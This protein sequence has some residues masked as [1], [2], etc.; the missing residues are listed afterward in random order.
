MVFEKD[1]P[2]FTARLTIFNEIINGFFR[3]ELVFKAKVIDALVEKNNKA[4]EWPSPPNCFQFRTTVYRH[5]SLNS[6]RSTTK[7]PKGIPVIHKSLEAEMLKLIAGWEQL[8]RDTQ[9][10]KQL[11]SIMLK[12]CVNTQQARAAIPEFLVR[13]SPMLATSGTRIGP[14]EVCA[15]FS[16][17]QWEDYNKLLP[18]LHVYNGATILI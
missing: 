1:D 15:P 14:F 11:L 13:H 16:P 7:F 18:R 3:A 10:L 9:K 12:P 2:F 4:L 8:E 5:S 17:A 6:F